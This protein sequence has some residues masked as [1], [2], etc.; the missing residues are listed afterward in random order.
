[1]E[2]QAKLAESDLARL[3]VRV[4]ATVTPVGTDKQFKGQIWQIS[5]V[6]D[7][8]TRQGVARIALSYAPA[9]RPGGF[10]SARIIAGSNQAPLLPDSAVQSEGGQ[11]YVYIVGKDDK[12][13]RRHL[14]RNRVGKGKSATGR[15]E[16]G[17]SSI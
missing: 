14:D 5:S 8:Q 3:S 13:I 12:V 7:P 10:A 15:V 11:N 9:L 16:L 1:M 4:P 17:G 2:M 6:I